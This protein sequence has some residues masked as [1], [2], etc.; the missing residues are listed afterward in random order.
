MSAA[1]CRGVPYASHRRVLGARSRAVLATLVVGLSLCACGDDDAA[2]EAGGGSGPTSSR[3]ASA[4][5][6]ATGRHGTDPAGGAHA[7][8]SERAPQAR[9]IRTEGDVLLSSGPTTA[10]AALEAGV[11]VTVPAGGSADVDLDEGT[12]LALDAG[13][14]LSIGD[15]GPAHALLVRGAVHIASPPED[16]PRETL[17]VATTE[18]TVSLSGAGEAYVA[19]DPSGTTWVIVLQ[20]LFEVTTGDT[21]ARGRLRSVDVMAGHTILASP[22]LGEISETGYA[23]LDDARAAA[24]TA[25]SILVPLE[26]DRRVRDLSAA[27]RRLDESLGALEAEARHGHEL[28]ERH[29][30]A[31]SASRS[32]EAMSIQAE[33]VTHA[34]RLYQLREVATARWERVR[35]AALAT[36][37]HLEPDP[38]ELRA[39]RVR[40]LLGD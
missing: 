7:E 21:D 6:S 23:R 20:G 10:G 34:Q 1:P 33:L 37:A 29:R 5:G 19:A 25:F 40:G 28:T 30:D 38:I 4:E 11:R 8:P 12:R 14:V 27:T 31:V 2:T 3:S 26:D 15:I 17:R 24:R 35:V 16:G 18:A 9:L 39:D 22:R 13:T 32:D 36:T